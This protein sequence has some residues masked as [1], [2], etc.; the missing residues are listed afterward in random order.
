VCLS[1]FDT[2]M[3]IAKDLSKLFVC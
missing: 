3:Q 1:F 2:A